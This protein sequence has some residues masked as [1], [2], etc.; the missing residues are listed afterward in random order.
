[1]GNLAIRGVA[2]GA[3][4][5]FSEAVCD[6]GPRDRPFEEQ[7]GETVVTVVAAGT[8]QY[9]SAA[10]DA[11]LAP[12]SLLLGEAGRSFT[13][14][15]DHGVGDRCVCFRFAPGYLE[16][17]GMEGGFARP[18][19]PPLAELAPWVAR[20]LRAVEAGPGEDLAELGLELAGAAQ[21]A[22]A[23]DSRR[24]R[25]P[26]AADERRVSQAVRAIEAELG[27]AHGLEA[28]AARAGMS[29]FHFLRVFRQVVGVTPRQFLVRARLRQAAQRLRAG[30]GTVTAAALE[31]GFGDL[32][33]FHHAFRAEFGVTPRGWVSARAR[34]AAAPRPRAAGSRRQC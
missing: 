23:G 12:G 31:A 27:A 17:L 28:M 22:A 1:M 8:F 5:S 2:A 34:R 32:S 25:A 13:C 26:S 33:H 20:T 14:R 30:A 15:H 24:G 3:G 18:S 9:R 7:H 19:L 21:L 4:W 10:G 11:V 29:A 6:A 16:R